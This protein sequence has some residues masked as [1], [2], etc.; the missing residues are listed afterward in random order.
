MPDA[1]VR[2]LPAELTIYTVAELHPQW[3]KWLATTGDA[4]D[5]EGC[6][7][8]AAAVEQADAAGVQ[9]LL[10]LSSALQRQGR[11]LQLRAPSTALLAACEA[12]GLADWAA[13]LQATEEAA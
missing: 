6:V 1:H 11:A 5:A 7:V 9:L 12:L 2:A 4:G 10:S 3:L 8:D 13:S